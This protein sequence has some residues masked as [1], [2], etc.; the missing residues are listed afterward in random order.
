MN[1]WR[2]GGVKIRYRQIMR[3]LFVVGAM[4]FQKCSLGYTGVVAEW[5]TSITGG[6]KRATHNF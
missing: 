3:L 2:T 4:P 6:P 1:E 5:E